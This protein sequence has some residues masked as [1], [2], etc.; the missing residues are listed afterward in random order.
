M[1][2]KTVILTPMGWPPPSLPLFPRTVKP[3]RTLSD[4]LHPDSGVVLV[5]R[6][7]IP[8][9]DVGALFEQIAD[10]IEQRAHARRA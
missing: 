3:Q 10:L 1:Y 9:N 8:F 7:T 4:D 5:L 6:W 2:T